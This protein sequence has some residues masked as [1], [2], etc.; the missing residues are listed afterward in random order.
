MEK[1]D[2]EKSCRGIVMEETTQEDMDV[3]LKKLRSVVLESDRDVWR[4]LISE[5]WSGQDRREKYYQKY[6]E[7]AELRDI[8]EKLKL[9][10][11]VDFETEFEVLL[12]RFIKSTDDVFWGKEWGKSPEFT[13]FALE[14]GKYLL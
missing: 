3:F 10:Y 9:K 8:K 7:M 1:G 12:F 14:N 2:I 13:K 4:E 6:P 5:E 11:G